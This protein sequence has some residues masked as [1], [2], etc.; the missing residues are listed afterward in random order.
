M[1]ARQIRVKR[2][3]MGFACMK[4]SVESPEDGEVW[5]DGYKHEEALLQL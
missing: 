3:I 2:P 5:V 1:V 4:Y